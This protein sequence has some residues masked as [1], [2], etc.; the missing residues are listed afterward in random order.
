MINEEQSAFILG[1]Q[2]IDNVLVAFKTMH[3]INQKRTRREGWM[4][5]KLDMSKTCDRVEWACL[6]AIMRKM[7]LPLHDVC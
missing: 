6:E 1:R 5:I 7:D 3:R 4:A 2:I